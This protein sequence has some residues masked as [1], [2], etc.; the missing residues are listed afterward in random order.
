M[1]VTD[2]FPGRVESRGPRTERQ[3]CL[4]SQGLYC[5]FQPRCP[6][7]NPVPGMG[8]GLFSQSQISAIGERHLLTKGL[9]LH[10]PGAQKPFM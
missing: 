7:P 6:H 8:V 9:F 10:R 2:I 1:G 3:G 4:W 5:G